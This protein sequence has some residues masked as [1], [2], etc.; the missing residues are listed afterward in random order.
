MFDVTG[1]INGRI[2]VSF[3]PVRKASGFVVSGDKL[4]YV[5]ASNKSKELATLLGG[6]VIDLRS[7]TVIPGFIDTHMHLDSL[8]LA[9]SS[10]NLKDARSI[11][12]LKS[13]LK[14]FYDEYKPS[15][16]IIGRGWDQELFKERRWPTRWDIDEVVPNVPVMLTRVCGHAAVVNTKA[17]EVAGLPQKDLESPYFLKNDEGSP[18]GVVL[19]DAIERFRNKMK[20]TTEEIEEMLS[21]ALTYAASLGVTTVGFMSCNLTTF[22][23]LQSLRLRKALPIRVRIYMSEGLDLILAL[24]IRRGFG[25]EYLKIMG[26]KLFADGSLG[27][28]TALLSKPYNDDASSSGTLVTEKQHLVN[29][30]RKAHENKLQVAIH[31]IGDAAVDV[32]L[33][34][35]STFGSNLE[36]YRH[37]IEHASI[38]RPEQ[39][40]KMAKLGVCASVQP[41]F[42]ISDWWIES[43]IGKERVSWAYPFRSMAESKVKVGF[44][45]DS[46]VEPLNPWE[47]VYAAVTRGENTEF[48]ERTSKEKLSLEEALF[49]YTVGSAYLL[50][51]ENNVGSLEEGKYADFVVV[52]KDPFE[53]DSKE[54]KNIKTLMT[55]VAG[56]IVFKSPELKDIL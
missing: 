35:Y 24:G 50:F 1:F 55:V 18:T 20:F 9:L 28:R 30:I 27:A 44:S 2:Y 32:A 21:Q 38:V 56:K 34:A 4:L 22:S 33:E 46:P 5:G 7:S 37:R 49:H 31:A 8:G 45:T 3:N 51:E 15:S 47:T 6:K 39:V 23:L 43:R 13:R 19:E 42:T 54:L 10:L 40:E 16:W 53:V 36:E 12:E 26:I 48:S 52:E 41:H 29:A 11:E 14:T 17:F 25:D